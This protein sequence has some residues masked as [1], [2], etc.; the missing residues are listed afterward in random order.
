MKDLIITLIMGTLAYIIISPIITYLWIDNP[1]FTTVI[2]VFI[3]LTVGLFSS[4][5]YITKK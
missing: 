3:F 1:I 2:F 5:S 4:I